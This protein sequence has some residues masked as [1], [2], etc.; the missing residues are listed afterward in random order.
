MKISKFKLITLFIIFFLNLKIFA[1]DIDS[2][3][4]NKEIWTDHSAQ[5]YHDFYLMEAFRPIN[6]GL[7][8]ANNSDYQ[9]WINLNTIADPVT[10]EMPTDYD[11]NNSSEDIFNI[12]YKSN[13]NDQNCEV[14]EDNFYNVIKASQDNDAD[15]LD[16]ESYRIRKPLSDTRWKLKIL[17]DVSNSNPYGVLSF[18]LNIYGLARG[19]GLYLAHAESKYDETGENVVVDSITWV[20]AVV[21]NQN[22]TAGT[23]SETY[24]ARI[25]HT[26]D[27]PGYGTIIG[28][29]QGGLDS[30]ITLPEPHGSFP[31][32]LPDSITTTNFA[33]NEDYLL[34]NT[35]SETYP[36]SPY[37]GVIIQS[38]SGESGLSCIDR[39]NYWSYVPIFGY[40]VYDSN[41]DRLPQS[42]FI[43]AIY[44]GTQIGMN[45]TS[46][47]IETVCKNMNDGSLASMS[48]CINAEGNYF[49]G[50]PAIDIPDGTVVTD[51]AGNSYYIRVLKPRKVYAYHEL[52]KCDG[53]ELQD[54][55]G[56]PDHKTF[57]YLNENNIPPS[58]AILYNQ[59]EVG[60]TSDQQYLGRVY[61]AN[62]DDDGDRILNFL[63]AF[64]EDATKSTDND[65]DGIDDAEDSDISQIIMT[66]KKYLDKN[67]FEPTD[68]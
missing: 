25:N 24:R 52:S 30:Q 22:L 14:F 41:G 29:V 18:D 38:T 51:D 8:K 39:K 60:D 35:K 61:V 57:V 67:I 7:C 12:G 45:G 56:T 43:Q 68:N 17:E 13:I 48:Q 36:G 1:I 6:Q 5:L 10:K 53:L 20:D 54:T 32:G 31:D 49:Q 26:V 16:I 42:P 4:K 66:W 59:Y 11:P 2:I 55:I 33:Y 15:P 28:M 40:G 47:A 50:I 37:D 65:Y 58:G 63:D 23:V 3:P 21:I 46:I 34:F 19:N 62:E 64:P 27:G 9:N 44:N